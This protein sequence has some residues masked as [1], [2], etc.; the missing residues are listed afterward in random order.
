MKHERD[1]SPQAARRI[2]DRTGGSDVEVSEKYRG[3]RPRQPRSAVLL[4]SLLSQQSGFELPVGV[5]IGS[6]D[7][8]I[9]PLHVCKLV[10]A[11]AES[12]ILRPSTGGSNFPGTGRWK[13][14]SSLLNFDTH[15]GLLKNAGR[16]KATGK[17][18]LNEPRER[19]REREVAAAKISAAVG[20]RDE[21]GIS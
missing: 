14:V 21:E 18:V 6:H 3:L 9:I 19:E 5:R 17:A 20:E 13:S 11:T 15:T 2:L 12:M 1:D 4:C 8:Y 10:W 16:S 7:D